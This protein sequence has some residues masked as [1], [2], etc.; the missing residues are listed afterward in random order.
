M[1]KDSKGVVLTEYAEGDGQLL[2]GTCSWEGPEASWRRRSALVASRMV[3]GAVCGRADPCTAGPG[4][5]C[6]VKPG[7]A[8]Y[9]HPVILPADGKLRA[10]CLAAGRDLHSALELKAAGTQQRLFGWSRRGRRVAYDIAKALNYLH[11]KVRP[12]GR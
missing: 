12:R 4:A 6:T 1:L 11:S 9:R 3:G 7:P 2:L 10:S 5:L 8:I